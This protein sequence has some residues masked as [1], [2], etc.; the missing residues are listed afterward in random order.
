L[1]SFFVRPGNRWLGAGSRRPRVPNMALSSFTSSERR[2]SC[3]GRCLGS[4][5][6]LSGLTLTD[7][8]AVGTGIPIEVS[9]TSSGLIRGAGLGGG[10]TIPLAATIDTWRD[11]RVHA[12]APSLGSG[13][14]RGLASPASAHGFAPVFG[15]YDAGTR[16]SM[17]LCSP[18]LVAS[19]D[20]KDTRPG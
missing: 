19:S 6:A 20:A 16:T 10:A 14:A 5:W 7:A 4:G 9:S 15:T 3:D 13:T 18:A 12:R 1:R 17:G 11:S 8:G 2:L